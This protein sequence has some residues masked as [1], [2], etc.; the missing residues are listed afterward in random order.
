MTITNEH[1]RKE[2][3]KFE[4]TGEFG[5]LFEELRHSLLLMPIN[6][7]GGCPLIR[8]GD[9]K[10]I[11]IFTDVHEFEKFFLSK[12]CTLESHEFNIYL[13]LLHAGLPEFVINMES[14]RFPL[15][16]EFL[17]VMDTNYVFDVEENVFT[18]NEI[19]RIKDSIDNSRIERFI[20]NL[21]NRHKTDELMEMLLASD[22]LTV[23]HSQNSLDKIEVNG[24]ISLHLVG[25][26]PY[27]R[28]QDNYTLIFTDESK[29]KVNEPNIYSQIVNL[30]EF[31]DDALK[32]D[33]SGIVINF[34]VDDIILSRDYL[35]EFLKDFRCPNLDKYDDYAFPIGR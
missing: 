20:K 29:I 17:K 13:E 12:S 2:M 25:K 10:F 1:L 24:V 3:D 15:T 23:V 16:R 18:R 5:N 32:G 14:E 30:P 26:L 31:I 35:L 8:V 9:D 33:L 27:L 11:P 34:R 19:K 7:F 28:T 6:E 22:L 21:D 4:K